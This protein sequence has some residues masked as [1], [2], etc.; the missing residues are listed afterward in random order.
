LRF[1]RLTKLVGCLSDY[2]RDWVLVNLVGLDKCGDFNIFR[3]KNYVGFFFQQ[4]YRR[5]LIISSDNF[6]ILVL[7][8]FEPFNIYYREGFAILS[9]TPDFTPVDKRWANYCYVQ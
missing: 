3:D 9:C 4:P 2:I 1:N 5:S 8:S 7:N 6:K